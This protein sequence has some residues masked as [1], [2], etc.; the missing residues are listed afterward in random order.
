M[1]FQDT[2]L[3]HEVLAIAAS[4]SKPVV[5]RFEAIIHANNVDI[6]V[7]WVETLD[8]KR[9]YHKNYHD[10]TRI[11]VAVTAGDHA[12]K[13]VPFKSTL[14][15]TLKITT[16]LENPSP[17]VNQEI[18][19][20]TVRYRATLYDNSSPVLESNSPVALDQKKMDDL[21]IKVFEL[22]LQNPAIEQLRMATFSGTFRQ[23][24]GIDLIR[25]ALTNA[26]KNVQV[27]D[28]WRI[29][30]V[31]VAPNATDA[32]REHILVKQPT[33]LVELPDVVNRICGGLFPAGF[34]FYL[35]GNYWYLFAG[36]DVKAYDKSP[37]TLTVINIPAN[38]MPS[39][40]RS[41]RTT[42]TQLIVIATGEA[43]HIDN[44]EEEQLN[45]G[46]GVRFMDAAKI[47]EGFVSVEGNKA[48]AVKANNI[49]EFISESRETGLQNIVESETRISANYQIESARLARR[50]GSR[51]MITWEN[52]DENLLYPG[53]PVKWMYVQND[54]PEEIYG[55]LLGAETF[56]TVSNRNQKEKRFTSTTVMT[57]FISRK[58]ELT[59]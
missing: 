8:N 31:T 9:N 38:R 42:A 33:K 56:Y 4:G 20:R 47:M 1:N 35:Q 10:D 23:V 14:E 13:I 25:Y 52:S 49:C 30:G 44:S 11:V 53:M 17:V 32:V 18:P 24:N 40:E 37:R 7:L 36:Y 46:N 19:V 57:I 27:D 5:L 21:D 48:T 34:N 28:G 22:Q 50:N 58:I 2:A 59:T 3:Y 6:P 54:I 39:P 45:K 51:I 41:Y 15:L 55:I 26:G 12:Y 29:K 43:K 16:L